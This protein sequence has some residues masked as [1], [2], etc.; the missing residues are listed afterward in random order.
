MGDEPLQDRCAE[1]RE[2]VTLHWSKR[3]DVAQPSGYVADRQDA[4]CLQTARD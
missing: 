2:L 3:E 1:Q 4:E